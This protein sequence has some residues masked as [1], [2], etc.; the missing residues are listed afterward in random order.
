[1][2]NKKL[3]KTLEDPSGAKIANY[4]ERRRVI[5]IANSTGFSNSLP[6]YLVTERN[7]DGQSFLESAMNHCRI[8]QCI[9]DK[10]EPSAKTGILLF[11][12]DNEL[13]IFKVDYRAANHIIDMTMACLPPSRWLST[14]KM[15]LNDCAKLESS[16]VSLAVIQHLC[17]TLDS[18]TVYGLLSGLQSN[19]APPMIHSMK[20]WLIL[21][22]LLERVPHERRTELLM[23]KDERGNPV[24]YD[25]A[26]ARCVTG[27]LAM[28]NQEEIY[29]VLAVTDSHGQSV[30]HHLVHHNQEKVL[31][32][33][34]ESVRSPEARIKLLLQ[35]DTMGKTVIAVA[36]D[37]FG[38]TEAILEVLSLEENY[39][40][41]TNSDRNGNSILQAVLY[42]REWHDRI[43]KIFRFMPQSNRLDAILK[44]DRYGRALIERATDTQICEIVNT[45][46]LDQRKSLFTDSTVQ[47]LGKPGVR[48]ALVEKFIDSPNHYFPTWILD[49]DLSEE[50]HHSLGSPLGPQG[51]NRMRYLS[52][53]RRLVE[54]MPADK[55]QSLLDYVSTP[56]SSLPSVS[57][58]VG[59]YGGSGRPSYLAVWRGIV[60]YCGQ[61]NLSFG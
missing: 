22:S 57:Q 16:Q 6:D 8:I 10:L 43:E 20:N 52:S 46:S 30:L 37:D 11:K 47:V 4:M 7:Q 19:F 27:V 45:L 48:W 56:V 55:F 31:T 17:S 60:T 50:E 21:S 34:L 49:M 32:A 41:L 12:D 51:V 58:P 35:C 1:M 24:L 25:W 33:I 53:L 3:W 40:I 2:G 9:F 61:I 5:E 54:R 18:D 28:L 26:N 44:R 42:S 59:A 36:K 14:I 13:V 38:T 15:F 29:S 23:L 39:V